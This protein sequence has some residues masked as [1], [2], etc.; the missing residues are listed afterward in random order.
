VKHETC[1]NG[2]TWTDWIPTSRLVS[3]VLPVSP[4]S[5]DYPARYSPIVPHVRTKALAR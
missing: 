3:P 1:E 5:L 2:A 4:V